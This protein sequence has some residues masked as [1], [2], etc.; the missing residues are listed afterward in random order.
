M[1]LKSV[2]EKVVFGARPVVLLVFA[3][4]T[5][6]MVFFASQLKVDAGFKKQIPLQ[7]EYMKTFLDYE[8]DFGG[9]NRV[10]VAVMAKDG[11]MFSDEYMTVLQQVTHDVVN[12]ED[13]DDSRARSLFTPNVRFIEVVEDGISGGNV[14]PND[15][16]PSFKFY[17][18]IYRIAVNESLNALGARKSLEAINGEEP[19]EA[20]GPDLQVEGEQTGRAIEDALMRI[21]PELRSVVVLRHLMHLSY[22]DMGDILGLPEKTVKSRLHSARMALRQDLLRCGTVG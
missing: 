7:H 17:S 14:I 12:L 9:A 21:T 22:R 1:S 3:L 18:W 2:S 10:L 16:D 13:T 20:P 4:V 5:A 19:D 11:N 15:Y 6:A 8:A